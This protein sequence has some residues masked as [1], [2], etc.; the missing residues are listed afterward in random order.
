MSTTRTDMN[1]RRTERAGKQ[2]RRGE[3]GFTIMEV[4]IVLSIIALIM[5]VLVV[6]RI[7]GAGEDAKRR[8]A[9]EQA[10]QLAI[11]Y[12]RWSLDHQDPCPASVAD[13]GKYVGKT[14]EAKDP[15]GSEYTMV[16][17]DQSPPEAGG[18][19]VLSP[20]PDRRAGSDDDVKSWESGKKK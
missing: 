7:M 17:G 19:G 13:L 11:A 2:A 4:L 12:E 20:G 6:P 5:G 9:L 8:T 3:R 16:C 10:R 1:T 14:F 18:F 15:W